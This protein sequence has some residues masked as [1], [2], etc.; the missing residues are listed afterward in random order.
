MKW[1]FFK[2]K[3]L[4]MKQMKKIQLVVSDLDGTLLNKDGQL[5]EE[6]LEAIKALKSQGI[7]FGIATGR[8]HFSIGP[9]L[10]MWKLE[11]LVDVI[12]ANNGYEIEVCANQHFIYGRKLALA[13]LLHI[14]DEYKDLPGNFCLYLK[15]ALYG[16]SMDDFMLRV[17][18]KNHLPA[19]QV[20]LKT[21]VQEDVEKLLLACDPKDLEVIDGFYKQH[22]N[23]N[24][25]GFKSQSYLFEFM[26]P[27]VSKLQGLQDFCAY[28]KID[29]ESVVAF[30]DNLN[31][32]EM[33]QG[34]G[35]GVVMS[36][37]DDFV[38]QQADHIAPH[39]D[40]HG[41]AQ[42]IHSLLT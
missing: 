12:I 27:S 9:L 21:F 28:A 38:K 33:I 7:L 14:I 34:S 32:V 35:Y 16:Q 1:I 41:F 11:G 2:C 24:Y 4:R 20:D 3:V 30:G 5:S 6:N 39:H 25:R 17:S 10:P 26:H 37:G 19:Y 23:P 8:P 22:P 42:V 29:I 40:E 13:S 15:D 18:K 36:N 31:D